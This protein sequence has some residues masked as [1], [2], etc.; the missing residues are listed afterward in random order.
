MGPGSDAGWTLAEII[1]LGKQ[2]ISVWVNQHLS[3]LARGCAS[4]VATRSSTTPYVCRD[5]TPLVGV[6]W[7]RTQPW[8]GFYRSA[9]IREEWGHTHPATRSSPRIKEA[10]LH[11]A[12]GEGERSSLATDDDE[13]RGGGGRGVNGGGCRNG[14]G[15]GA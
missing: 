9:L 6:E 13:S 15:N 4:R 8:E 12:V 11:S 7:G 1:V 2:R 3:G 14:G 5:S 10:S